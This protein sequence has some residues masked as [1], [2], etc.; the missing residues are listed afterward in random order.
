LST[1]QGTSNLERSR[2]K[3]MQQRGANEN[4]IPDVPQPPP[5]T[6]SQPK[7]HALI[8]ARCASSKRSFNS[9]ADPYYIQEV[10]MLCP[11]TKIPSP[12]TVSRDINM[13]YKF[14]AEVVHK[15]FSVS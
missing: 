12:A 9:V 3:C 13:M 1:S 6:Y 8:A 11:G 4:P 14:G 7:H 2:R 10:E 15:Y 5:L